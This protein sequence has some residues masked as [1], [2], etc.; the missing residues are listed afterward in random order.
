MKDAQGDPAYG[1]TNWR[2]FAVAAVVPAA[3]AGALVFGMANGAFAASFAVSGQT[4]K[5]SADKLDG[6]GFAQYGSFVE[7][8]DGTKIPVAMSGITSAK[9]YNL[10]QSVKTP[11]LPISLTIRAGRDDAKPAA[12]TNLLIGVSE[13]SGDAE[14]TDINIGQDASTL[15][16]GG[17]DAKGAEGM[18]GQEAKHVTITG[19]RQTAVSTTAG[20]F[21]LNGLNLKVNFDP[22]GGK[23]AECY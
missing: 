21:T 12:A 5:I 16:L 13:L 20:T 9:L 6:T 19:L 1:R 14:F 7:K 4:F 22:S 3:A 10:C 18:F 2:R 15:G 23:P 17:K 11:G 8:K